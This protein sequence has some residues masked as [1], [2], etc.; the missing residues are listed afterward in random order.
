MWRYL[1]EH[2]DIFMSDPWKEPSFFCADRRGF[3]IED[4]AAY[5]AI[6]S[7]VTDEARVGEASG[8][9]LT[10]PESPGLIRREIPN[11]RFV[12]LLRNPADRA[13]SL[14]KWMHQHG[15]ENLPTFSEALA[16]EEHERFGSKRFRRD[17]GQYYHNFMYFHSG[18]YCEQIERLFDTFSREQVRVIIF[19][20]FISNTLHEVRATY[21]FLDVD[22]SFT[23]SLEIHNATALEYGEQDGALR[24]ALL[25]RYADNIDNLGKLLGRDLARLWT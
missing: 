7:D 6:F 10:S 11:A 19:D 15:Y 13:W 14:Y 1:Q 12:V 16:A 9:Y 2:P 18:L 17:N 24:D 21:D 25:M 22:A 5:E 20:D 23:P 3:G 8:P 4:R